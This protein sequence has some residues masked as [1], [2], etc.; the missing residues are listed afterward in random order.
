[1]LLADHLTDHE[2]RKHQVPLAILGVGKKSEWEVPSDQEAEVEV[3]EE[4][5]REEEEILKDW[6]EIQKNDYILLYFIIN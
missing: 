3:E 4:Q 6:T 1:M 2:H 5:E